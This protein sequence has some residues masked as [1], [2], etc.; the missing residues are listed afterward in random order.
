MDSRRFLVAFVLA[1]LVAPASGTASGPGPRPPTQSF[2]SEPG[3]H[4]PDVTV[5]S[6]PDTTSGDILLAPYDTP[7]PGPMI[8]DS[9]GRLVWFRRLRRGP[10]TNLEVQRYRGHE[11]LTWWQGVFSGQGRAVAG[12]DMVLNSSYRTVAVLHAGHGYVAD[13]HEFQITPQGTALIDAWVPVRADLSRVGGPSRGTVLDCVVQELSIPSGRV[14]W[15]WHSLG[16]VPLSASYAGRPAG[17]SPYDYFHLNSIQQLPDGNLLISARNTWAVYKISRSTGRV[18]WTLGGKHSSFTMGPGTGFEWQHD[19]R[20]HADGTLTLF[21]DA[22][23]P[24][25]EPQSSAKALAIDTQ[26]MRASLVRQYDHSPP[27]LSGTQGSAQLLPGGD[28]FVGWGSQPYFSEYSPS[29]RQIFSGSFALGVESY[30]AYRFPWTGR[31]ATKPAMAVS[32]QAGAR[33][34]VYASWNGATQVTAW[35]VLGGPNPGALH[36]LGQPTPRQGFETVIRPDSAPAY[37]AVQA[38]GRGGGVLATSTVRADAG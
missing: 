4:P 32:R 8:L 18:L 33:P 19:A 17:S 2:R 13:P 3:L 12:Q 10:A 11:V 23:L 27:V 31:P 36:P 9:R 24:Q 16:H 21:D 5:T 38:L 34:W 26:T 35:R 7:Q 14:L 29:G 30:R 1:G 15:E 6:D 37:L 20:L 28:V 25:E 22:A